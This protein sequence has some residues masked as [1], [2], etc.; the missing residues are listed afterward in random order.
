V[1]RDQRGARQKNLS[2]SRSWTGGCGAATAVFV[3]VV[4]DGV[5]G[6]AQTGGRQG[7][8]RPY[9]PPVVVWRRLLQD[10]L[11]RQTAWRRRGNCR[12]HSRLD[13]DFASFGINDLG[14]AART[15]HHGVSRT[16]IDLA[17]DRLKALTVADVTIA[18]DWFDQSGETGRNTH[19]QRTTQA[20]QGSQE[21]LHALYLLWMATPFARI[22]DFYT[23]CG[24]ESYSPGQSK[25]PS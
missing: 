7:G 21:R 14:H 4:L 2:V 15:H 8:C 1:A 9:G 24:F 22:T 23:T 12:D 18:L 6:D 13:V 5:D 20:A 19:E 17:F 11:A 3:V 16:G 25:L 10:L